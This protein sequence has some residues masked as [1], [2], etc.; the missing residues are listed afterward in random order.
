MNTINIKPIEFKPI[1]I[2]IGNEFIF[3]TRYC[4]PKEIQNISEEFVI[5]DNA[6][7]LANELII[8]DWK[9][10]HVVVDGSFV[11]G[12]FI[13]AFVVNNDYHIKNMTLSTLSMSYEN[14]DSLS[15]L[16]KG[17]FVDKLDL[18]I[19]GFHYSQKRNSIVRY[20]YEQLDIDDRF[21]MSVAD[22]HT[23]VCLFETHCSKFIVIKGSANLSSSKCVEEFTIET[24]KEL[25]DFQ[26][27][28]HQKI[29]EHYATIKK[30]IRGN[31]LWRC[32]SGKER[33]KKQKTKHK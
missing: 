25:Y 28:I 5:Y 32:I 21:Q 24:S 26:F 6:D 4:I 23:K 20:T 33:E 1:K 30:T 15:N 11:F 17:G 19:S 12:D 13:E 7:K 29:V 22:S 2:N 3:P 18:I 9:R 31:E 8:E 10:I 27:Q 14:V 16:L